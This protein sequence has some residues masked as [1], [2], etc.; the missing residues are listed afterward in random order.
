MRES[1]GEQASDRERDGASDR[2]VKVWSEPDQ[3]H[4]RHS[5]SVISADSLTRCVKWL[6]L[7]QA[8]GAFNRK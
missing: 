2:G 7:H 6:P 5:D 8:T 4:I 3:S 1:E